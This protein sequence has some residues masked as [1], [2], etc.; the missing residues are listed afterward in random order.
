MTK[1]TKFW[2]FTENS[3]TLR[4]R[5]RS[6]S[7]SNVDFRLFPTGHA[8]SCTS[9]KDTSCKYVSIR[10]QLAQIEHNYCSHTT[11]H[12]SYF[13]LLRSLLYGFF[14]LFDF[15][16]C[17]DKIACAYKSAKMNAKIESR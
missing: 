14:P 3:E 15:L 11:E 16:S 6:T 1:K 5:F 4:T 13:A 8:R 9:G 2:L 12:F 17:P 10:L 7:D